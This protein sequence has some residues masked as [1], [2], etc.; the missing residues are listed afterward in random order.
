MARASVRTAGSVNDGLRA[1]RRA[2]YRISL[3]IACMGAAFRERCSSSSSRGRRARARCR[4]SLRDGQR[5]RAEDFTRPHLCGTPSA[6]GPCIGHPARKR[7]FH[8]GAVVAA[9]RR[10]TEAQQAAIEPHDSGA[11]RI[12]LPLPRGPHERVQPLRLF[13]RR[14]SSLARERESTCGANRHCQAHRLARS[15]RRLSD[16]AMLD[17]AR[18]SWDRAARRSASRHPCRWHIRAT[19]RRPARAEREKRGQIPSCDSHYSAGY[20]IST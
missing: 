20:Y 17:R 15:A 2:A 5:D 16:A 9:Q 8:R 10:G 18:P 3:R 1:S 12:Q 13:R 6:R 7:L 4:P 11:L 19:A 14:P